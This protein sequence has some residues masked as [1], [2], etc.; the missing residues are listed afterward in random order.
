[1]WY[2]A[3]GTDI[4]YKLI[5]RKKLFETDSKMGKNPLAHFAVGIDR[6]EMLE[7]RYDENKTG[8]R[9]FCGTGSGYWF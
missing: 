7:N 8:R 5:D 9:F 2:C 3:E 6:K 1:M 4:L